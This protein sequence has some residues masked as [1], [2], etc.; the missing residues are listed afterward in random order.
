MIRCSGLILVFFALKPDD[1][2]PVPL[3]PVPMLT[4]RPIP[5]DAVT[6]KIATVAFCLRHHINWRTRFIKQYAMIPPRV[7][8]LL[9]IIFLLWSFPEAQQ[10]YVGGRPLLDYAIENELNALNELNTTHYNDFSYS[11]DKWLNLTGFRESDGLAW[12][13]L[14]PVQERAREHLVD[15]FGKEEAPK[16]I[17]GTLKGPLA[18][19]K[20]ITG[21]VRGR[22]MRSP[23][24]KSHIEHPSLNLTHLLPDRDPRFIPQS[25]HRNISGSEGKLALRFEEKQEP[26]IVNGRPVQTIRADVTISDENSAGDGWEMILYGQHFVDEG[27][28][29]LTTTSDKFQGIFALPHLAL[30]EYLYD[31]AQQN[32]NK[33]LLKTIQQQE[34]RKLFTLIPWDSTLEG[35]DAIF[36]APNCEL[37][38]YLQQHPL[39]TPLANDAPTA[40]DP[41]LVGTLENELRFPQGHRALTPPSLKMSAVV[42]SPDCGFIIESMGP[43]LADR[44]SGD[45]LTGKKTEVYA[46]FGR[47]HTLIYSIVLIAQVLLTIR[48][49]KDSS[50][51]STRS[52]IS[53]YTISLLTLGDGFSG[54]AFLPLGMMYDVAFPTLLAIAF[55]AFLTV[56]FFDLRFMMDVWSVQFQER[57]RLERTQQ[58]SASSG[59]QTS[60]STDTPRTP[61]PPGNPSTPAAPGTLPLPV[62]AP[63]PSTTDTGVAPLP[64]F[65]PSDQD[66]ITATTPATTNAQPTEAAVMRRDLSSLYGKYYITLLFIVF[67]SLHAS[68]WYPLPRSMYCNALAF[69][70]LSFWIPQIHRNVMRNCRKALL[71]KFVIGHSVLRLLPIAYFWGYPNNVL[72]TKPDLRMLAVLAGW[73]W[74]QICI[75]VVQDLVEP[76][77]FVPQSWVPPAYDYHPLLREDEEDA[78][79]PIG[80]ATAASAA[81]DEIRSPT[82][83]ERGGKTE[84]KDKDKDKGKRIFD[85]A[86]C[87]QSIEVPVIPAG[88]SGSLEGG[89]SGNWLARR[90]YMV[91]PCRHIFHTPCLEASMRYRL[92]CPICRETLPP[93]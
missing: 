83:P 35:H 52:R 26:S 36:G 21:Y 46:S 44:G 78:K 9:L 19:Y 17:D 51:P 28:T 42:F 16:V 53:F 79:M 12:Q 41:A 2:C 77:L 87:M 22:W 67:L 65:L 48:Q 31:Q 71:W 27:H 49:M 66:N 72:F 38:M 23:L 47:H 25:F 8:T 64:F 89:L 61:S 88:G 34:S 76:R 7:I 24:E 68:S 93:L 54:M 81:A 29:I 1:L 69:I 45:H 13:Q 86:I 43:P 5:L 80:F 4:A 14:E 18:V 33:S 40:V 73:V 10:P 75:L 15:A 57:R 82:S 32:L 74:C 84:A 39:T 92:S 85:C 70:Y 63:R 55:I 3:C 20:N 58:Q 60:T 50:T 90:Q 56:T 6:T 11:T 37:I 91:T 62:T 30:S 59:N